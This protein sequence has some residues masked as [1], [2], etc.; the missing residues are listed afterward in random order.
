[1]PRKK[2]SGMSAFCGC[3]RSPSPDEINIVKEPMIQP[4]PVPEVPIP[5]S[6]VM[7]SETEVNRKFK[8]VVQELEL[9][10][11]KQVKMYELPI[12]KKWQLVVSKTTENE[13]S[14]EARDF[15]EYYIDNIK[16]MYQKHSFDSDEIDHSKSEEHTRRLRILDGLR[17]ALRTQPLSF[18]DRFIE[19][20]GL[21]HLLNFLS[22]MTKDMKESRIHTSAIGC[23]KALMNNQ[24]GRANVLEHPDA[25]DII[26]RSLNVEHVK[27]KVSVLEILGPVCLIPGGHKKVLT[28]LTKF[29]TFAAERTRFQSLILDLARSRKENEFEV[30]LKTTI[31]TLVNALLKFGAGAETV[32]F[33]LHLR[34]EFLMLG[35][36]PLI[37]KLEEY[38]N[39]A[40]DLHLD[41][42]KLQRDR[43]EE[44]LRDKLGAVKVNTNSAAEMCESLRQLHGSTAVYPH[45]LSM[46]QHLMLLK[47]QHVWAFADHLLQQVSQQ[48]ADGFD[49]DI[50]V[51]EMNVQKCAE[52]IKHEKDV[53]QLKKRTETLTEKSRNLEASLHKESQEL[54]RVKNEKTELT[55]SLLRYQERL[56]KVRENERQ[57]MSLKTLQEENEELKR[58]NS[59]LEQANSDKAN[60]PDDVKLSLRSTPIVEDQKQQTT[61]TPSGLPP[62]P[63]PPGPPV[64]PGPPA[65]PAPSGPPAPPP[66]PGMAGPPG[67]PPPPR[68]P[69]L[70]PPGPPPPGGLA[71]PVMKQFPQPS[72]PV[73]SFNWVK[74]TLIKNTIFEAMEPEAA[75]KNLDLKRLESAFQAKPIHRTSIS[76]NFDDADSRESAELKL[77]DGRRSQN[78]SILLSRLKIGE[79]EVRTAVLTNDS[80]ERIPAELADQLLKFVPTKEEIETLN[81]YADD[82]HKMASV[83]RFFFEMGKILR[84]ENKLKA[85]AF[86]KKFQERRCAANF[87]ADAVAHASK[88]LFQSKSIQKLFLLVLALGN[89][90]NKGA[91]GNSPGFKL[92]SLSKLRDTKAADGKSTLLHY[93]VEEL[94]ASKNKMSLD[95]I[96]SETKHLADSVRVDL[97]QLRA[98]VKQLREGLTTCES[99]MEQL[100]EEGGHVPPTLEIFCQIAKTQMAD[101]ET[102]I[103]DTDETYQKTL[104]RF[105]EKQ[106]ESHDFFS[107]FLQLINELREA[108][109]ENEKREE[110]VKDQ[111]RQEKIKQSRQERISTRTTS[112]GKTLDEMGE[113]LKSGELFDCGPKRRNRPKKKL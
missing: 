27:T 81:Q 3:F 112:K 1:M 103:K 63:P 19:I 37:E 109:L 101:L 49:P 42:F 53:K 95:D 104:T 75:L 84:Y 20:H 48:C 16:S 50:A 32:E 13:S 68:A 83:D 64:Q 22:A 23:V 43:D 113:M 10:V 7:P 92:S 73:K 28:A 58:Q 89:Y 66:L 38:E 18:V 17:S 79:G 30:E 46:L 70:G 65:P 90:M 2:R 39:E 71:P 12:S 35:I 24:A 74:Q 59:M 96:E 33:R 47:N 88:E 99:E 67:P 34:Y 100:R 93:L 69:G 52:G 107:L 72:A 94:E 8:E 25:V 97:K 78:C 62:P 55:R 80:A 82:V 21:T 45:Y 40:L 61:P 54:E 76:R 15:P 6:M 106:M 85:I 44:Q 14:K 108:K 110:A 9:P 91:R 86:R 4:Q 11:D 105:G 57:L 31:M 29:A 87:N 102:H 77:I 98:E 41:V 26:T 36:V 111:I 5:A 56:E 60:L 51:L